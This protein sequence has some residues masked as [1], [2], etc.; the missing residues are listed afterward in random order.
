MPFDGAGA[1]EELRPDLRV[2]EAVAGKA[3]NLLL[4]RV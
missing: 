3:D 1:Q 2:G 4:L